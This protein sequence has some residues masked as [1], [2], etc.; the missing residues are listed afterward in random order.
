MGMFALRTGKM[1]SEC[2]T[3]APMYES[4]LSSLYDS[5]FMRLGLSTMRGSQ[6]RKPETSV[7]FSYTLAPSARATM[8]PEISEPPRENVFTFPSAPLP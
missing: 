7:Q 1:L 6:A 8:A 4:S 3:F 5:A 2:S